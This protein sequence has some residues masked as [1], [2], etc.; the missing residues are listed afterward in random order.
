MEP[1]F[2]LNYFLDS[3]QVEK[4]VVEW[5]F[6]VSRIKNAIYIAVLSILAAN[7]LLSAILN[8][9]T[10]SIFI[11]AA[12]I[13]CILMVLYLPS[14]QAKPL[15]RAYGDG[16]NFTLN[17]YDEKIEIV[18]Q[19]GNTEMEYE[20]IVGILESKNF[21]CFELQG[22]FFPV[23]KLAV[24]EDKKLQIRQFLQQKVEKRYKNINK[25]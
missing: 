4:A 25:K 13:F 7:F 1:I 2:S 17:I 11:V 3:K 21:Y 15:S 14:F 12:C 5:H 23:P 8:K 6:G 20:G 16:Q 19:S 18:S 10:L 9:D 22:R 24:D